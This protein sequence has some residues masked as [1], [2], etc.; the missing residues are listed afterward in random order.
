MRY[1]NE[2]KTLEE[3]KKLYHKLAKQYHPD[4][5]GSTAKMQDISSEYDYACAVL[6]KGEKLSSEEINEQI[7]LSEKYKQAIEAIIHLPGIQ[8]EV[9]GNWIWVTGNTYEHRSKKKGGTGILYEAGYIYANKRDEPS[10]WFFR[11]EENKTKS[12]KRQS[13][14]E[15]KAK[16]GS[17]SINSKFAHRAIR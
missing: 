1:F 3:V 13:L 10:A 5:G 2:C 4:C 11:T 6:L 12:Y 7:E 8:I 16:Y 17:T 15:I 14:E 9:V